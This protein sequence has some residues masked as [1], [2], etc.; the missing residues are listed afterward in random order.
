MASIEQALSAYQQ[1]TSETAKLDTE[2]ILCHVLD[3]E[4]SY[5]RTWPEKA[6]SESEFQNFSTL[7]DRRKQGE[8]VAYI[9][10]RQAFWTL[11][12]MVSPET[13]I[14]RPDTELLVEL[15]INLDLPERAKVLDLGAGTG[16][17]ALAISS[18]RQNWSVLGVDCA[19]E[20]VELASANAKQHK[21]SNAQFIESSWFETI[22]DQ[23][24][25][26]IVSNP[27]YI[28]PDDPHLDQG[29]VRFEPKRALVADHHGMADIELITCQAWDHM[30]SGA[31]LMLE[32]GYD[33]AALVRELLEAKGYRHVESKR[34]LGQHERVSVGQKP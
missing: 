33:Q 27:P 14:P 12:L 7:L 10:G 28:D 26:L 11:D 32:H 2:L 8:P 34:D 31:W 20:V 23:R 1:L 21:L 6:L 30:T 22:A 24:F 17:I 9:I 29:D 18:E 13:L 5:L 4:R 25:D 15:A 3:C 19:Q 16:A